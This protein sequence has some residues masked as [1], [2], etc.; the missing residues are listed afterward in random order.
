MLFIEEINDELTI[1]LEII[2][3]SENCNI[4]EEFNFEDNYKNI[5]SNVVSIIK[6]FGYEV[7]E[8]ER[9]PYSDSLYFIFCFKN[10][11]NDTEVKLVIELRLSDHELPKWDNDKSKRDAKNRQLNFVKGYVH[12]NKELL[13]KNLKDDEEIPVDQIYIKYENEFYSTLDDVYQK[14]REKLQAFTN[15]HK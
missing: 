5:I 3:I 1:S 15:K 8:K 7:L 12:N 6:E 4:N 2:T 11:Y 9:S 13:N 14:V 10:E